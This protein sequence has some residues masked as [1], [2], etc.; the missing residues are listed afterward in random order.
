MAGSYRNQALIEE[1]RRKARF[2]WLC[3]VAVTLIWSA[4]ILVAPFAAAFGFEST[5]NSIYSFFSYIC[6]QMPS[7]S[8]HVLE[9]Q[10]G[11]CSRCSG[12]YF[13]LVLG[14]IGYS[15]FRSIYEINPLPRIWL[16]LSMIP[17]GIDWSLTFFGIWENTFASRFITGLIL[18]VACAVFIV[19]AL[20]ELAQILAARKN[21][22]IPP[23]ARESA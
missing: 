20:A 4:V 9:H 13:G 6:H 17:I 2:F 7:R 19:P 8:F 23:D 1:S 11:V 15:F 16:I 3:L 22:G 5:A 10:F 14:S 21:K 18:G 12:V